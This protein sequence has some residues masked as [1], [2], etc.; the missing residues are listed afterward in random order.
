MVKREDEFLPTDTRRVVPARR[1]VPLLPAQPTAVRRAVLRSQYD[2][3][4]F[5][6][7]PAFGETARIVGNRPGRVSITFVET[8]ANYSVAPFDDDVLARGWKIQGASGGAGPSQI[9]FT[10]HTHPMIVGWEWWGATASGATV[11]G[12]EVF[13]R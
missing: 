3:R 13:R 4:S 5:S 10:V 9:V 7:T 1:A 2:V 6:I 11:C 8:G 12:W